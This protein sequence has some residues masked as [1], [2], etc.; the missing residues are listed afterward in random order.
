MYPNIGGS[1]RGEARAYDCEPANPS[2]AAFAIVVTRGVSGGCNDKS[3]QVR[4]IGHNQLAEIVLS[5]VLKS[6]CFRDRASRV[7]FILQ[8]RLPPIDRTPSR[9][10][11]DRI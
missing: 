11:G 6:G 3:T 2:R 9:G 7:A 4:A 1:L 10:E 8:L 5:V